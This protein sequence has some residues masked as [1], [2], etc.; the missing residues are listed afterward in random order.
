MT[1]ED[2]Y[3]QRI[4][5]TVHGLVQGVGFRYFIQAAAVREA[6]C[7]WVKNLA[8]GRVAIAAHG[9]ADALARLEQDIRRGPPG[10]IVDHVEISAAAPDECWTGFSIR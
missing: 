7:G 1:H 5:A 8:D 6:I 2:D 4:D 9:A 3:R 10:A